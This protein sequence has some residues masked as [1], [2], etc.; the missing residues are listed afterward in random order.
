[1]FLLECSDA[2]LRILTGHGYML[3]YGSSVSPGLI[4]LRH[5]APAHLTLVVVLQAPTWILEQFWTPWGKLS[6]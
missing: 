2:V 6:R 3:C 1:M 5:Q 4:L